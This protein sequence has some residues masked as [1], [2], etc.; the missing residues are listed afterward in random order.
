MSIVSFVALVAIAPSVQLYTL[1]NTMTIPITFA[2]NFGALHPSK[3]LKALI[4]SKAGREYILGL[5]VYYLKHH[6]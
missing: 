4:D 5:V 2:R 6:D 1:L 3:N